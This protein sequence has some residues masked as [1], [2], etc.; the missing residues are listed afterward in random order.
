MMAWSRRVRLILASIVGS[1]FISGTQI[2]TVQ[3]VAKTEAASSAA[4][5]AQSKPVETVTIRER[6]SGKF[7]ASRSRNRQL[8]FVKQYAYWYATEELGLSEQEFWM[9]HEIWN[10]E[11]HWNWEAVGIRQSDGRAKGIPQVKWSKM[12]KSPFRQVEK[13]FDYILHRY[14]TVEA[15]YKFHMKNGWY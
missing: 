14:G 9:V 12:I 2:S 6:L 8:T 11:S 15:A 4:P 13:G 1:V 7:K 3:D 5:Q 10:R